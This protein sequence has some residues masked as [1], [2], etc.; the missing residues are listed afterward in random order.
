[1]AAGIRDAG[2]ASAGRAGD[3]FH[4]AGRGE[5][6]P[7][8]GGLVQAQ[9]ARRALLARVVRAVGQCRAELREVGAEAPRGQLAGQPRRGLRLRARD[10]PLL[11]RQLRG[12]GVPRD[13][14]TRI[15]AAAVQLAAQRGGQRRPL[16]GLQAHHLAGPAGQRLLG[17]AQQQLLHFLRAHPPGLRRQDERQLLE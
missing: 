12:G 1:M 14:R 11:K 10:Q 15:D 16:R 8:G 3:H 4:S 6:V 13:A 9:P 17:Q 7:G 5:R 2:L